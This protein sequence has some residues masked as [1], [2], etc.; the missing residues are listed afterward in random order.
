[1]LGDQ[2]IRPIAD[3][4][5]T[6]MNFAGQ[7]SLKQLAELLRSVAVLVSNDSG[8]LHLAAELGTQ[9]VGVYTCTSPVISGPA[10][11]GHELVATQVA[12]AAG[13]HKV[14]PHRG[15]RHLACFE[16]LATD[17]VAAALLRILNRIA[18]RA[19]SA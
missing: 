10:G 12:C 6:A 3:A 4:G 18:T 9:V 2:I 15:D 19:R 7:T 17:R 1:M 11:V 8:P 5:L 14:C 13:Y 16:D